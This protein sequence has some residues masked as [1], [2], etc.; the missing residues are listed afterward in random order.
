MCMCEYRVFRGGLDVEIW[1][2][3]LLVKVE[4]I[5]FSWCDVDGLMW[6]EAKGDHLCACVW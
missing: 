2:I 3:G 5:I 4:G 6:V 1:H